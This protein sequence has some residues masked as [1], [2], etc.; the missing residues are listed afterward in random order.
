MIRTMVETPEA[1][2]PSLPYS[3]YLLLCKGGVIYAGITNDM[4]RRYRQHCEGRGAKFTRARPPQ[5]VLCQA[6]IGSKSDA[7]K[8]E[9]QVKQL[10]R[11]AKVAFVQNLAG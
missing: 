2:S 11:S 5:R 10:P 8:M 9:Y 7:L 1:P 4:E 6:V 3:L